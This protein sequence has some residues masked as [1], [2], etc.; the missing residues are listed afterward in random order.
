MNITSAVKR[1]KEGRKGVMII[2]IFPCLAGL[3]K[4]GVCGKS[5]IWLKIGAILEL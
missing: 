3:V 5:P 2:I 1:V 4:I